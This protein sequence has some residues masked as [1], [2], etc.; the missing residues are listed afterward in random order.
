MR[1]RFVALFAFTFAM[2]IGVLWETFEF[3]MDELAGPNMPSRASRTR[4]AL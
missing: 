4:W 1:P 2:T 3:A